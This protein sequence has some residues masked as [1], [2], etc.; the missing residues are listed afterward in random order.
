M[1]YSRWREYLK[2]D[3]CSDGGGQSIVEA[4]LGSRDL[5][6]GGADVPEASSPCKG[7]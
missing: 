3:I 5:I 6:D 7:R 2:A 1:E 4:L